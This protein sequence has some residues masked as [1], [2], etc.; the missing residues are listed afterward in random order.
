MGG[1]AGDGAGDVGSDGWDAAEVDRV[2][3]EHDGDLGDV[4]LADDA[5]VGGGYVCGVVAS[6]ECGH[7]GAVVFVDASDPLH[8][9]EA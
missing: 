3:C 9:F 2:G 1:C 8:G 5:L 4:E 6:R 7:L